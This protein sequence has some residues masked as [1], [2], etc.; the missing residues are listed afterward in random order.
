VAPGLIAGI[1]H[2]NRNKQVT[3]DFQRAFT[4][5]VAWIRQEFSEMVDGP[6]TH[7]LTGVLGSDVMGVIQ[8]NDLLVE[9]YITR[10]VVVDRVEAYK[11]RVAE[12]ASQASQVVPR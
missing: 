6:L 1:E 11:K 2:S 5:K 8:D 3:F 7:H 9:R 12:R 10:A 4:D